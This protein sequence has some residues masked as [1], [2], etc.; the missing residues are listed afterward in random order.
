MPT[1]SE[2]EMAAIAPNTPTQ[3]YTMEFTNRVH[4]LVMDEKNSARMPHTRSRS[5][6]S[7]N[8]ASQVS[9]REKTFTTFC[10]PTV[11]ST[12]EV[13]SPRVSD[14]ALNMLNV[15]RATKLATSSE[16]GVTRM[17]ISVMRTFSPNMKISV[18]TMVTA[19]ENSCVKPMSRPSEIWSTSVTTRLITSPWRRPSI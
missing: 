13:I 10:P 2:P 19:P 1:L 8:R 4:G 16:M 11:S 6:I 12:S 14:C 15:R 9:S 18:P 7:S 5:L 3:A 17:T